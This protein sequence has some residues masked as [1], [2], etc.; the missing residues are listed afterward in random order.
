MKKF[1][2]YAAGLVMMLSL[3][4]LG[5]RPALVSA[6]FEATKDAACQGVA[7]AGQSCGGSSAGISKIVKAAIN[8]LSLIVGV[9]AVVMIIISGLKYT[10]SGGDSSSVSSAKRSLLYAVIGLVIVALTQFI[11]RFVIG[12]I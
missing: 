1:K 5:F 4:T 3:L 10:T 8:L 6:Q 2:M 11:I 7:S 12:R 9:A